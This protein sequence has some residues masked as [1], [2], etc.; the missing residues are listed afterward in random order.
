MS[1]ILIIGGDGRQGRALRD[2]L[3]AECDRVDSVDKGDDVLSAINSTKWD[4]VF[5]C[6]P[7]FLN[8]EFAS[9]C[10]SRG[11][12]WADL[13]GHWQTS[14]DI[15]GSAEICECVAATDLG[16]APGF[17]EQTVW[18]GIQKHGAP[19]S[20]WMYC[21]G[22]PLISQNVFSYALCFSVDGLV[23]EYVN[24][25]VVLKNG[26]VVDAEPMGDQVQLLV[27]GA[28]LEAANTS[29]AVSVSSLQDLASLGVKDCSYRTLRH[30]HHWRLVN[31][32]WERSGK[33]RAKLSDWIKLTS[34]ESLEDVVFAKV[35]F[36]DQS[37]DFKI[38]HEDDL[39]AM[40]RGTAGPAASAALLIAS[41][42]FDD[43]CV[44]TARDI[45]EHDLFWKDLNS[46][47]GLDFQ[48]LM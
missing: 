2:Y 9:F 3:Y 35:V 18:R 39:S 29:G 13:G 37:W 17:V 45:G 14:E 34:Q 43:R 21:G 48:D 36:D 30:P 5:S 40:Q 12:R 8:E 6:A 27:A 26:E 24:S 31:H 16:L 32:A 20:I 7:Y 1:R 23:N 11:L 42:E 44:V 33:S 4:L 19:K 22:L 47:L 41:G 25:C 38:R 46:R 28:F 10:F 15:R